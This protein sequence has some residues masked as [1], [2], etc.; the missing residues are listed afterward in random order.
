M[1]TVIVAA[2]LGTRLLKYTK[3]VIPKILLSSG[4]QPILIDILEFW[5]KYSKDITIISHSLYAN[6]IKEYAALYGYSINVISHDIANGSANAI[7]TN[8]KDPGD[9]LFT[10]SDIV[11]VHEFEVPEKTTIFTSPGDYRYAVI[12]NKIK[13]VEGTDTQG[14]IPGIYYIKNFKNIQLD[15]SKI[16]DF[17]DIFEQAYPDFNTK[18]LQVIDYGDEQKY[19]NA[20]SKNAAKTRYFN[21]IVITEDAVKKY[22]VNEKGKQLATI[23]KNWYSTIKEKNPNI[24]PDVKI[25]SDHIE[26]E[27][28]DK[29]VAEYIKETGD[30]TIV[31]KVY[32][33]LGTLHS[34]ESPNI[35][36]YLILDDIYKESVDKLYTRFNN[37]EN[38][39]KTFSSY[40]NLDEVYEGLQFI[41][42]NIFE[43]YSQNKENMKYTIIHGDSQFSNIMLDK[44]GNVKLI[45]PR[46][47]FGNTKIYG[48]PEYD[49]AK[50]LYAIYGY[51]AFNNTLPY[52]QG[53]GFIQID[54]V[55]AHAKYISEMY[56]IDEFILHL[57][58]TVILFGLPEYIKNDVQKMLDSTNE[59]IKY[60]KKLM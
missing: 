47:Y 54:D 4:K 41:K 22:Y 25:Y 48:L 23:E 51:D 28:L 21:E 24:I 50:S 5:S 9:Y 39:L 6:S 3:E 52:I 18:P 16:L 2:G 38:V 20:I 12:D 1:K 57:W 49:Y 58:L 60:C 35:N 37:I 14:N 56:G 33:L 11:P 26:L 40:V 7:M 13:N 29:T 19:N 32:E 59:A 15:E 46:G 43:Y 42:D 34:E 30:K 17:I 8:I 44:H 10:W 27:R 55:E 53:T 36:S 31:Y 45:D